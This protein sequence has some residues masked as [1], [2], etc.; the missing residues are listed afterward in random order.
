M[1]TF[2]A[3]EK[4]YFTILCTLLIGIPAMSQV[5]INTSSPSDGSILDISAS[6]KGL[7]IPRVSI[8][9]LT[10]IAPVSVVISAEQGLI[11]YNTNTATGDGFHY[12]DTTNGWIPFVRRIDDLIDGKSD[13]DGTDDGS[14]IYLGLKAGEDDD[15]THNKNIGIGFEALK[16]NIGVE[17][18]SGGDGDFN[19]A[20]G[21]QTM[22]KNTIGE[23]NS[24]VG[25]KALNDNID[26]NYNAAMGY[27]ALTDNID[28][29]K[30]TAMGYRAL[31]DNTTGNDNSGI[32]Y[33]TLMKNISGGRNTGNGYRAGYSNSTASE[34]TVIGYNSMLTNNGNNNVAI[35]HGSFKTNSITTPTPSS[36]GDFALITTY[37]NSVSVGHDTWISASNQVRLGNTTSTSIGGYAGWS[38]VSDGRFKTSVVENVVGLDFIM[39]LRPVTYNLDIGAIA[40]FN[41]VAEASRDLQAEREK[42]L[43]IQSGFIAQEVEEAARIVGYDFHGVDAPKNE[44]SHYGLRYAE[45]VVPIVKATQEQQTIIEMQQEKITELENR[46]IALENKINN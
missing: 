36:S 33:Q 26:G 13:I 31:D 27:Q 46:L 35:G 29:D 5:G 40:Q 45:F 39:K 4:L 38:N 14:S 2:F 22:A 7:L 18:P 10:T 44:K 20:I 23:K 32:G 3:P 17:N 43:E 34:S 16:D 30:N 37:T 11:V 8:I 42:S 24:A 12:W 1:N 25:Y 28:G 15:L 41:N 19:I 21:Y 6:D 9:D